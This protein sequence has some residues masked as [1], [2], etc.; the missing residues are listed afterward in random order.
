MGHLSE[1]ITAPMEIEKRSM[2]MIEALMEGHSFSQEELT[3]V[4]RVIHTTAD[5]EYPGFIQFSNNPIEAIQQGIKAGCHIVTDTNMARSGI[6]KRIL[7]NFGVEVKCFVGHEKVAKEAEKNGLTRSINA[8]DY[9]VED[10]KNQIF[11]F[12]NAPTALVRLLDLVDE[13]K[14]SPKGIIGVPVGFVGAKESKELLSKYKI[15]HITT[16]S[17]KGGSNVAAAILN[18]ILYP[19][20]NRH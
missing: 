18:A 12:G 10:E 13:G 14:V 15:P 1:F 16:I 8:V 4:K 2:E 9:A 7:R 11:V 5:F 17:R 19:I 3:V 6:N 20:A